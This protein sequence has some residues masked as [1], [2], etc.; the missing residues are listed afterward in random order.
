MLSYVLCA[1]VGLK[2]CRARKGKRTTTCVAAR[3]NQQSGPTTK[4]KRVY[5]DHHYRHHQTAYDLARQSLAPPKSMQIAIPG[6]SYNPRLGG[7]TEE[8]SR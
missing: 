2:L 5:P 3:D 8:H 4:G 1:W 6:A 7:L